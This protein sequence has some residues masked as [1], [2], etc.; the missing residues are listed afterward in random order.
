MIG[1]C[2]SNYNMVEFGGGECWKLQDGDKEIN[3]QFKVEAY[4]TIREI[5]TLDI[6]LTRVI[7]RTNCEVFIGLALENSALELI[8]EQKSLH[9][10]DSREN[11]IGS[12]P[13][14]DFFIKTDS[15][16]IVRSIY[17]HQEP[18]LGVV[19]NICSPDSSAVRSIFE[20]KTYLNEVLLC[21]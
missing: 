13:S 12:R 15:L 2:T 19:I 20:H 8:D 18:P 7:Q 3:V 16:F 1:G 5:G 6:P 17:Q 11:T 4:E 14:H 10:F 21:E 9:S